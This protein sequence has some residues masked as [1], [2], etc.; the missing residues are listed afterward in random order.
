MSSNKKIKP[1]KK[2]HLNNNKQTESSSA[3]TEN[4]NL[5]SQHKLEPTEIPI[6]NINS[7]NSSERQIDGISSAILL[8]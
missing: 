6:L 2:V 1:V 8:H 3:Q 5:V 4:F 7:R